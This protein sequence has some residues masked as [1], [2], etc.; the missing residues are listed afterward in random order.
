MKLATIA[1]LHG[2]LKNARKFAARF[3]KENVDAIVLAGDIASDEKQTKNLTEI[4]KIFSKTSKKIYVRPGNHEQYADYYSALKKFKKNK[5]IIDCSKNP[6]LKFN[7]QKI[8]FLPGSGVAHAP[9]AGFML[10]WSRKQLNRAK[11]HIKKYKIHFFKKVKFMFL[12]DY[13]KYLDKNTIVITHSP[14]NF[15][16]PN[17]IDVAVFGRIIKPFSI[18]KEHY[19]YMEDATRLFPVFPKNIIFTLDEAT[20]LIKLG[21]PIKVVRKNVG[22]KRL[23]KLFRKK[24]ITKFICGDIHEAGG[25]A[26][27]WKGKQIKQNK[28]SKELFYNCSPGFKG[29]AGI[30]EFLNNKVKYKVVRA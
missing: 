18:K 16:T 4:L 1:C 10:L 30:V 21:Y 23:K 24:G 17:S 12:S 11:K 6:I 9:G 14:I 22:A 13:I 20:K 28:W 19:K 26:N 5:S 15:N 8:L 25:R 29:R 3:R 27:D 7:G 2:N